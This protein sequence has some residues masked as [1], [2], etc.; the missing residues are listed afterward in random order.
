MPKQIKKRELPKF[1]KTHHILSVVTML[2][3]IALTTLLILIVRQSSADKEPKVLGIAT[4]AVYALFMIACLAHLIQGY[5][6]FGK[7]ESYASL[8]S[9]MLTSVSLFGMLL[10]IQFMLALMFTSAGADKLAE[11]VVG[12]TGLTDFMSTQSSVWG[13]FIAGLSTAV[14]AGLMSLVRA[15][16]R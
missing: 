9:A 10:N 11:K 2:L 8:F 14:F 15:I 4:F 1:E 13:F 7:H 3:S 12:G 16:R 5:I 6:S